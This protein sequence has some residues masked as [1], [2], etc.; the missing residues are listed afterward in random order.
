[1][2]AYGLGQVLAWGQSDSCME[3]GSPQAP[4][5]PRPGCSPFG[6]GRTGSTRGWR[7][8][9]LPHPLPGV[10]ANRL[11]CPV[12]RPRVPQA[13]VSPC[14]TSLPSRLQVPLLP[15][16]PHPFPH[17]HADLQPLLR[18][19]P[20]PGPRRSSTKNRECQ[21]TDNG[22]PGVVMLSMPL[23]GEGSHPAL[24]WGPKRLSTTSLTPAAQELGVS[25]PPSVEWDKHPAYPRAH[26]RTD[27]VVQGRTLRGGVGRLPRGHGRGMW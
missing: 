1:M 22:Q 13:Q 5:G 3:K 26:T 18:G 16:F 7:E 21:A 11:H 15:T 25:G 24:P 9:S 27:L 10:G 23:G 20:H 6:Q 2:H 4:W 19:H 8:D 17:P 14:H 12:P